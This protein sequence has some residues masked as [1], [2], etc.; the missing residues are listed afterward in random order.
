M[1]RHTR[2]T[3]AL[4]FCC[5]A[6]SGLVGASS[7]PPP[8][9]Y[10]DIKPLLAIHCYKCH[11]PETAKN[12]LRLDLRERAFAGGKSGKTAIVPGDSETSE[13][14]R[15]IISSDPDQRMPAKGEPLSAAEMATV[16][17]WI[18]QG[19]RWPDRD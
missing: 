5:A 11:G 3:I 13:I 8:R 18:D 16:R 15:R 19:A 17:R 12:G 7:T 14:V 4:I 2:I 10:D 1:T 9:F 6:G